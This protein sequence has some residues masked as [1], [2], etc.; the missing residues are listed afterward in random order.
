MDLPAPQGLVELQGAFIR[1]PD[2]EAIA[3]N[4]FSI[5][6]QPG[7]I[8]GSWSGGSGKSTLARAI[9]GVWPLLRGGCEI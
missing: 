8:T 1:P 6:F 5:T 2:S 9:V 7:T 3:V 4:N